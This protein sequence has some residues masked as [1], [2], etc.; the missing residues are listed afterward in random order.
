MG[1]RQPRRRRLVPGRAG[2]LDR[3]DGALFGCLIQWAI[4]L[5]AAVAIASERERGTW[6][7]LLTSPLEGTEI[8]RGKLWGSLYALRRLFAATFW[9]WTVALACGAMSGWDYLTQV[10]ETLI[11]GAFLAAVGVRT[12][13]T[14][15]GRD[16]GHG[17]DDRDLAGGRRGRGVHRRGS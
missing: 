10:A 14:S 12:S 8:V 4:G 6:D 17:G 1:P 7:A 3:P 2:P 5:R 15:P 9:A 11:V 13:L 16:Q